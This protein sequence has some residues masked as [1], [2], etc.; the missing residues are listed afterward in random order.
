MKNISR[1]NIVV[2]CFNALT[3]TKATLQSLFLSTDTPYIL[4][5]ID[6]G[7]DED[8]QEF[9][10][11]LNPPETCEKLILIRNDENLGVGHAYNQGFNVSIAENTLY[12]CFCNNDLYFSKDWLV[13]LES[14]LDSH[15][16]VAMVNPLRPSTTTMYSSELS[17][18]DRLH[19]ADETDNWEQELINFTN[20]PISEFNDFCG[21]IIEFNCAYYNADD[22]IL[23]F[24]DSLSTC[25]CLAR[26]KQ[27]LKLDSFANPVFKGYGGEDID[28]SWRVMGQ[29][30]D[31]AIYRKAYVHHFR[32]KSL[33]PNGL[34]RRALLARSNRLLYESWRHEINRFINHEISQGVDVRGKLSN[35]TNDEYWLL[36]QLDADINILDGIQNG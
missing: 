9:L 32:G 7:S 28:T 30:Y 21:D 36:S 12:T 26:N 13:V 14:Y 16:N 6:N 15:Q 23:K 22:T 29:G 5:I 17:T 8:T 34:D 11:S 31:C 10:K 18:M 25:V 35:V 24:P 33:K 2:L 4:T 27:L 1:T 3:Y 19:Q 20:R